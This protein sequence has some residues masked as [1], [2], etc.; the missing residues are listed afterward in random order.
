MIKPSYKNILSAHIDTDNILRKKNISVI[1]IVKIIESI[2]GK[3]SKLN[4]VDLG[5]DQVIDIL[6]W[7]RSGIG[8]SHEGHK[9]VVADL[10]KKW[11]PK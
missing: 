5:N 8:K 1:N 10:H 6:V 2:T 11:K 3:K 7:F 9:E 4:Y